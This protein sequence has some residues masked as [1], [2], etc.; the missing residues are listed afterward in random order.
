MK[1]SFLYRISRAYFV[2][3]GSSKLDIKEKKTRKEKTRQDFSRS[4]LYT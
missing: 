2:G 3:I 4:D 1:I